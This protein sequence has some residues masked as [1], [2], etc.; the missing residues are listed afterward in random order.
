MNLVSI[1]IPTYNNANTI[2]RSVDSC[3]NQ[4]YG[5]IEIIV[6]DD[7]STDNTKE[8]LSKYNSDE[9]FKYI[10]QDNQERSTA[11]NH[12]LDV[13]KGKYIQF[14]DSDD[15]IYPTKIEK[16]VNFLDANPEYFLVY[17][18]VEYKN[19]LGQITH[20]LEPKINGNID[21]K[22]LNN[23][24]FAIHSPLFH[25]SDIRFNQ[26]INRLEDWMYW[27]DLT[28]NKNVFYI[29]DLLCIVNINK[30][31]TYSYVVE[32]LL[33][34]VALYKKL[35]LDKKC[36]KFIYMKNIIKRYIKILIL[37]CCR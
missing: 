28:K 26:Q 17:C 36:G 4:T 2:C 1:I 12:G 20:T 24:F 8:V 9:R 37:K 19:E 21:Y 3:I 7:G 27:I 31:S 14:L 32:M 23:N 30:Q 34:E 18:G 25:N 6:I 16:Q 5:N 13:A 33:G 10:Y 15:E 35:L 22:I 11:R 29:S